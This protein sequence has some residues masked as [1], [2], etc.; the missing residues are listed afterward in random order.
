[1]CE[2][3]T[4][5]SRRWALAQSQQVGEA[6]EMPTSPPSRVGPLQGMPTRPQRAQI[7]PLCYAGVR[8]GVILGRLQTSVNSERPLSGGDGRD[9][10]A[11]RQQS[12]GRGHGHAG[13]PTNDRQVPRPG[14]HTGA[15][16]GLRSSGWV[17]P[18]PRCG[19][20]WTRG[21]QG[22]CD[23]RTTAPAPGTTS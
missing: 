2:S 18:P 10:G 3:R 21:R 22:G 15:G 11:G 7:L 13:S 9:G 1:M 16:Q 8:L 23:T 12:P 20:L 5:E 6:P 19:H 17:K 4:C 14:V